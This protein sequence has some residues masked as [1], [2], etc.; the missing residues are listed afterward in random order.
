MLRAGGPCLCLGLGM[1]TKSGVHAWHRRLQRHFC[2]SSWAVSPILLMQPLAS[3]TPTPPSTPMC[4]SAS[5][6]RLWG[7]VAPFLLICS[8]GPSSNAHV[9]TACVGRQVDMCA[10]QRV[11]TLRIQAKIAVAQ[12]T[13][14]AGLLA[15]A[16]ASGNAPASVAAWATVFPT[17]KGHTVPVVVRNART[18]L[19]VASY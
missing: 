2:C 13:C 14:R 10:C 8:G 4:M 7:G 5:S 17:A 3:R 19:A 9:R 15:G 1:G 18:C 11:H 16:T 6:R 12:G